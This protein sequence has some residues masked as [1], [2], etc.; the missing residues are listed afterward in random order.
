VSRPLSFVERISFAEKPVAVYTCLQQ[1]EANLPGKDPGVGKGEAVTEIASRG[2]LLSPFDLRGLRLRNRV[3][4]SPMTRAR[5][6]RSGCQCIDVRVLYPTG[7]RGLLITEGTPISDQ[8]IGWLN[9]PGIY[10][11]EQTAAWKAIVDAVHAKAH[12]YSSNSG[13]AGVPPIAAFT[14]RGNS[15]SPF[16]YQTERGVCSHAH[17]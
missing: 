16:G 9:C 17:R 2:A 3:V 12:P 4:M 8:A 10:S 5:A 14:R 13:T 11:D 1:A 7:L 15:L 6:G